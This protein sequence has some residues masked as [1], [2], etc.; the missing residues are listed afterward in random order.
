MTRLL[1]AGAT[2]LVGEATLQ[3]ALASP[4]VRQVVAPTR[5]PLAPH[6]KLLNPVVDFDA[7]PADAV[8]WRADAVACALGTTIRDAGSQDAFRRVDHD[9][10]LAIA[11]HAHAHGATTF[12]LVSAMGADARSRIF[13]SRTKGEVEDAL[14]GIGFAS[15]SLLRPGLLGG[16]RKQHRR[17]EGLA[18]RVMAVLDTVLPARYRVVPAERVADALL[19][20]ALDAPPGRHVIPSEQLLG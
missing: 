4:R 11:H 16:E 6:P 13:Y 1:L 7:L 12:A 9:Y 14:T 15:L 8:W 20:A 5:R 17:G 2:G 19:Q 3:R 18:L 10:P